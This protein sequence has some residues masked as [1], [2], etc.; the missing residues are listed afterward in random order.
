MSF[1]FAYCAGCLWYMCFARQR[2]ERSKKPLYMGNARQ[3]V[4]IA[5]CL[6]SAPLNVLQNACAISSLFPCKTK[7]PRPQRLYAECSKCPR[8]P[9]FC[10]QPTARLQNT[11]ACRH[12]NNCLKTETAAAFVALAGIQAPGGWEA[13]CQGAAPGR[14]GPF[15]GI[16]EMRR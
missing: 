11:A 5:Q 4:R 8:K 12:I 10:R 14:V 2:D 7:C 13:S 9:V 6:L 15:C 3:R 1:S 16:G